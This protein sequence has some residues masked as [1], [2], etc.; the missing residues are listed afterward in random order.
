MRVTSMATISAITKREARITLLLSALAAASV[1]LLC[2]A[3]PTFAGASVVK[4]PK[5]YCNPINLDYDFELHKG[6]RPN[7]R[8]TADPVCIM[9][10]DKYYLFATNQ[11]GYWWSDNDMATWN[12]V[13]CKFKVNASDD[14]VCA[15]AAWPAKN[16][17]LFLPCFTEK[18]T[19]PLYI[20]PDPAS[21]KWSEAVHEFP[22]QTWDPSLFEDHDGRLYLYYG[23]SNVYPIYGV[24]LDAQNGYKP[25]GK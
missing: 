2:S 6:S 8:S 5:T 19:M 10:K 20:S 16:G 4:T 17:I 12:F 11:E 14:Q 25:K 22:V 13:P 7:H 3:E 24:E 18:D 23:S 21:G 1:T 9:Y 15:P